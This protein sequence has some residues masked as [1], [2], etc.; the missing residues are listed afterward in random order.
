M[1]PIGETP[2]HA[3]LVGHGDDDGGPEH[4]WR[5]ARLALY[6]TKQQQP[7]DMMNNEAH[8]HS[9]AQTRRRVSF[10]CS[11]HS[12]R[13]LPTFNNITKS[14]N[15]WHNLPD[16]LQRISTRQCPPT[17]LTYITPC[18]H[19]IRSLVALEPWG[20]KQTALASAGPVRRGPSR[21]AGRSRFRWPTTEQTCAQRSTQHH[22]RLDLVCPEWGKIGI[23][24]AAFEW[25]V[26][27][28]PLKDL[29]HAYKLFGM[30]PPPPPRAASSVPRP[31]G[32]PPGT[33][34]SC[35]RWLSPC[36]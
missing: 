11:N 9:T 13:D 21:P 12:H 27:E 22:R 29:K 24:T 16:A 8:A 36:S 7:V 3:V 1:K 15:Y 4:Y 20:R 33:G 31:V 30:S 5:G 35:G 28:S 18:H 19:I 17:L 32:T 6:A 26:R 14:I 23:A 2:P 34:T 25:K 10:L